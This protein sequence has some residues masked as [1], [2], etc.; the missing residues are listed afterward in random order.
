M[1]CAIITGHTGIRGY[2]Q[3][4]VGRGDIH[5]TA[6]TTIPSTTGS[7]ISSSTGASSTSS[8]T[9]IPSAAISTTSAGTTQTT[10]AA[11]ELAISVVLQQSLALFNGNCVEMAQPRISAGDIC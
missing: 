2:K 9:T 10:G 4:D 11:T 1:L 3:C 8:S 5:T 7:T 6:T